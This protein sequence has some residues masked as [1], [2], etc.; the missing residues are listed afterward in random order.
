MVN[1][2]VRGRCLCAW[3][4]MLCVWAKTLVSFVISSGY[5][6][7]CDVLSDQ[8]SFSESHLY[9]TTLFVENGKC[10]SFLL[11]SRR[12]IFLHFHWTL[13]PDLLIADAFQGTQRQLFGFIYIFV[14]Y[15]PWKGG[16]SHV[17]ENWI[18]TSVILEIIC[19]LVSCSKDG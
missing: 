6:T 18:V 19:G 4:T 7:C 3:S 11:H 5:V 1:N 10:I 9:I 17:R 14:F 2:S 8:I 15:I 16:L 12:S 13:A